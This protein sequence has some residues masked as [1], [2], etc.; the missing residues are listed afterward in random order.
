MKMNDIVLNIKTC[1]VRFIGRR[2]FIVCMNAQAVS[3]NVASWVSLDAPDDATVVFNDPEFNASLK[4][5]T[6]LSNP[7]PQV[8]A[9]VTDNVLARAM[10]GWTPASPM[11]A[12]KSSVNSRYAR[13]TVVSPCSKTR[14][15]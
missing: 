7:S 14:I 13:G 5:G 12:T 3:G 1:A 4:P 11:R 9:R 6:R 10:S 15:P 2:R 8:I